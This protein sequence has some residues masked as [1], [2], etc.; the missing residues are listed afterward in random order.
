M[1]QIGGIFNQL[2]LWIA[3]A[4]R[5]FKWVKKKKPWRE[6]RKSTVNV[7]F[8]D[9]T[10]QYMT[11]SW[12][13]QR[14]SHPSCSSFQFQLSNWVAQPQRSVAPWTLWNE[15]VHN[16]ESSRHGKRESTVG[17]RAAK[18]VA[19]AWCVGYYTILHWDV[20]GCFFIQYFGA[21]SFHPRY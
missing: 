4:R 18:S 16:T 14:N 2:K 7:I 20:R 6:K 3:V 19:S 9:S 11:T 5:N 1:K 8:P 13:S 15:I 12:Q 10:H 17:P 21:F